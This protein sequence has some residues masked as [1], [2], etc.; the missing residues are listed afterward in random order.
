LQP[1]LLRV[2]RLPTPPRY[3]RYAQQIAGCATI[4]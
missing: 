4:G 2:Q 3:P 1:V